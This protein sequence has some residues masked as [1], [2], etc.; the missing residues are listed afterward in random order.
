MILVHPIF[1]KRVYLDIFKKVQQVECAILPLVNAN[2]FPI[3]CHFVRPILHRK[4]TP[5]RMAMIKLGITTLIQNYLKFP[6]IV[7]V[8]MK[9]PPKAVP[10]SYICMQYILLA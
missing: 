5:H 7:M 1:V 6:H 4:A 3:T 8:N 9:Q 2:V 10:P